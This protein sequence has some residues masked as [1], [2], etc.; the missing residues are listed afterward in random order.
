[1]VHQRAFNHIKATITRSGLGLSSLFISLLSV[2]YTD[3]FSKQLS[4][5]ITQ[6]NRSIAFFSQNYPSRNANTV[7]SIKLLAMSKL[8]KSSK[9]ILRGQPVSVY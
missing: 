4:A 5:V 3:A 1:M 6:D 8:L 2:S 7:S 9:G